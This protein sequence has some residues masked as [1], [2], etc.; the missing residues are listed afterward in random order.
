MRKTPRK[1][2]SREILANACESLAVGR[3]AERDH[4]AR[5]Q[6][7]RLTWSVIGV[8]KLKSTKKTEAAPTTTGKECGGVVSAY[9]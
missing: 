8:R 1:N 2:P 4:V 6:H 3:F 9:D 5:I 7:Q